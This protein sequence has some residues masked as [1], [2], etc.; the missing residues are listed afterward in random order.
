[1][2]DQ[3]IPLS[4][5]CPVTLISRVVEAAK[6]D[7]TAAEFECVIQY[8]IGKTERTLVLRAPGRRTTIA[9]LRGYLYGLTQK[10]LLKSHL[11]RQPRQHCQRPYVHSQ[12]FPPNYAST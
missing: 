1:M 8:G 7:R 9:I 12:G 2:D 5:N 6:M 3:V 11:P 4:D 10:L